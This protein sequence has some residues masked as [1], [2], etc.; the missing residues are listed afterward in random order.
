MDKRIEPLVVALEAN[1][2]KQL[3][4]HEQLLS[5]M[6]QKRSVLAGGDPH[7][8]AQMCQLENE[9]VQSLSELEKQRLEAVAALTL[10]LQPNAAEP[11][12]MAE[13]VRLLPAVVRDKLELQRAL[14]RQRMEAVKQQASIARRATESLTRHLQGLVDTIGSIS[15]GVTTYAH[16]GP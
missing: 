5:L 2:Q 13:L 1:L 11:M 4:R 6:D 7:R 10:L 9:N 15:T 12:S 14:L 3:D 16:E 8:L